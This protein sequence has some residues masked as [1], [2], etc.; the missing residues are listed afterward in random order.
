MIKIRLVAPLLLDLIITWKFEYGVRDKLQFQTELG[1][2]WHDA[3]GP[4]RLT[5]DGKC[6]KV[7]IADYVLTKIPKVFFRVEREWGEPNAFGPLP[8][9]TDENTHSIKP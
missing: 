3:T 6:Y 4:Y 8:E 1:G 5:D 2:E 7:E 9:P